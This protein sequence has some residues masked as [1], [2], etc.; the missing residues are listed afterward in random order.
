MYPPWMSGEMHKESVRQL[1]T[2]GWSQTTL[3]VVVKPVF[4]AI[5]SHPGIV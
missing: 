4:V 3:D 2:C 5:D 1:S